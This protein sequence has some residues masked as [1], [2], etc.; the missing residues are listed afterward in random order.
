MEK[1]KRKVW[2][3]RTCTLGEMGTV[4]EGRKGM[5][6]P[7]IPMVNTFRETPVK[8]CCREIAG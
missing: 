6:R 8:I 4:G 7:L 3:I 2:I 5:K 1:H